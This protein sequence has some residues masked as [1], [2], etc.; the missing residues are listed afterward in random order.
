MAQ[1]FLL[2]VAART[3]SLKAIYA[4]GEETAYRRFCELRWPDTKGSPVCPHCGSGKAYAIT[5]RRKFK[6]KACNR[7]FSV[8]SGTMFASHK[9]GFVDLLGA[10]ALIANAAKGLSS[11]QLARCIDVSY[12]TAFV[13]AHKL[14]E[15]LAT[16]T[17]DLTLT[18]TI[19]VDGAYVGGHV[20]H[21][22]REDRRSVVAPQWL[23]AFAPP[24]G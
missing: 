6:C 14:R 13:L 18:D 10:I 23:R 2:S 17:K 3:L 4:Q 21:H 12:K 19:E 15:A 20:R 8:T 24:L 7:Q 11:L 9:L 1:H 5:T 16:E 22:R